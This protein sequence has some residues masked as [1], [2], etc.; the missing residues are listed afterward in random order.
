MI[1]YFSIFRWFYFVLKEHLAC[2]R[3]LLLL[4]S[5]F[6][7]LKQV[8]GQLSIHWLLLIDS[9]LQC[10]WIS[11]RSSWFITQSPSELFPFRRP[12]LH[13]Q[14]N[15]R[16]G[17]QLWRSRS[18]P[19]RPHSIEIHHVIHPPAHVFVF[20]PLRRSPPPFI[21]HRNSSFNQVQCTQSSLFYIIHLF[22]YFAVMN[23]KLLAPNKC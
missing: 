2:W 5:Q 15:Q 16:L 18:A 4:I 12:V 11:R 8:N 14:T 19:P 6:I 22:I 10:V 9:E 20:S 3:L 17:Q 7:W 13:V 21:F 23:I 1:I